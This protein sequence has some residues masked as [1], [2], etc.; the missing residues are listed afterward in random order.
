VQLF[1]VFIKHCAYRSLSISLFQNR[2]LG[3][4][5][6]QG[7]CADILSHTWP[8]RGGDQPRTTP[9]PFVPTGFNEFLWLSRPPPKSQDSG[10]G[11]LGHQNATPT[12]HSQYPTRPGSCAAETAALRPTGAHLGGLPGGGAPAGGALN[13]V[14]KFLAVPRAPHSGRPKTKRHQ[15]QK[16]L[17]SACRATKIKNK[18]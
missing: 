15:S 16:T 1:R 4:G 17:A 8:V 14:L 6:I 2:I 12:P 18:H 3:S 7:I 9:M 10:T 5:W 13:R 11:H